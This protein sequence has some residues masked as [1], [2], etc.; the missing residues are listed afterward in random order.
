MHICFAS[1]VEAF[2][3]KLGIKKIKVLNSNHFAEGTGSIPNQELR[4]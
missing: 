4:S 1:I 3:N 2:D